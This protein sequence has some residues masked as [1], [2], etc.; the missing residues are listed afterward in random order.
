MGSR[1]RA[2]SLARRKNTTKLLH[3]GCLDVIEVQKIDRRIH[4]HEMM[5]NMEII[6]ES[7]DVHDQLV[8]PDP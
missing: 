3:S 2:L 8:Q 5:E 4:V 6:Y 7:Y 1:Q